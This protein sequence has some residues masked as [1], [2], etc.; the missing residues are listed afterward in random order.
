MAATD[1][2]NTPPSFRV[3]W[4]D[5]WRAPGVLSVPH[6]GRTFPPDFHEQAS[7][8]ANLASLEDPFLDLLLPHVSHLGMPIVV[9]QFGRAYVDANRAA[10][11][12]DQAMFNERLPKR[13]ASDTGRV[14][15]G[16]GTFPRYLPPRQPVNRRRL[17]LDQGLER[18]LTGYR[19][20]HHMLRHLLRACRARFG[21]AL[22][23]DLHSMPQLPGE[24]LP[25]LVVGD[26]F[27]RA[28]SPAVPQTATRAAQAI[29]L[30]VSRNYP[31]AGGF[32]TQNYGTPA[33][34]FHALQLEF[35]RPLYMD[36][37]TR[38]LKPEGA[39]VTETLVA[40]IEQLSAL[41][42]G[43]LRPAPAAMAGEN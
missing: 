7:T 4:P 33:Q 13:L 43:L 23:I 40:I 12:W 19:P 17:S 24:R 22:L 10:S 26:G 1:S 18:W 11:E 30:S 31:Y 39:Y 38:A 15:A 21:Y 34:G 16:L 37:K 5:E 29:G 14:R 32:I 27:G 28:C 2:P 25:D 8:S 41:E 9:A 36:E 3:I 35:S 6:S 42:P 20:Y